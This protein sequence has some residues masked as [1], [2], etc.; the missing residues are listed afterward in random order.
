M[1]HTLSPQSIETVVRSVAVD[2]LLP[3]DVRKTIPSFGSTTGQFDPQ[4]VVKF[5]T[6]DGAFTWY[7]LEFDGNDLFFGLVD[8]QTREL[9]YFALSEL[10]DVRGQFG[11]GIERD[12]YFDPTPLSELM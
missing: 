4:A 3:P 7:V 2:R 11:L 5:F 12:R 9:G 10:L 6:P 1:N 8:G